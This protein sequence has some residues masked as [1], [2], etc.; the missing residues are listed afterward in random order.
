MKDWYFV[1]AEYP[2]QGAECVYLGQRRCLYSM[3]NTQVHRLMDWWTIYHLELLCLGCRAFTWTAACGEGPKK[4]GAFTRMPFARTCYGTLTKEL[5]SGQSKVIFSK[6]KHLCRSSR[7]PPW[8][9]LAANDVSS[10]WILRALY[11]HLPCTGQ[12]LHCM[13][14]SLSLTHAHTPT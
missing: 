14:I 2:W 11:G 8:F 7:N 13:K 4:P 10:L 1:H 3:L 6:H 12:F 9:F 5:G